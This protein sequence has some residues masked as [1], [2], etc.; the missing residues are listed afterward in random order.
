MN[1]SCIPTGH[2]LN[3][4]LDKDIDLLLIQNISNLWNV[5]TWRC[6]Q[7]ISNV[8]NASSN[9]CQKARVKSFNSCKNVC[10]DW[11]YYILL[12]GITIK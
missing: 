6:I 1:L 5:F 8:R 12:S 7:N 2:L 11:F 4:E 9:K 10:L 3:D